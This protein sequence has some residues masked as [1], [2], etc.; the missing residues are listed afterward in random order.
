MNKA[1]LSHLNNLS[2][3]AE[4]IHQPNVAQYKPFSPFRTNTV[5]KIEE[6]VS[7]SIGFKLSDIL[8]KLNKP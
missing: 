7:P 3:R 1:V 4:K 6:N 5:Q 8:N 2:K